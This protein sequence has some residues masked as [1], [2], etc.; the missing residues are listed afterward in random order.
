MGN[1]T[2]IRSARTPYNWR[3]LAILVGATLVSV[4]LLTPYSS[5]LQGQSLKMSPALLIGWVVMTA[6]VAIMAA[7]GLA[8]AGRIGLGLPF[9]ESWL[10]GRPDWVG[11]RKYV[12]PAI[13]TGVLVGIVIKG[14]DAVVFLPRLPEVVQLGLKEPPVW[15]GFLASFFGGI[16]EEIQLRLFMLTLFAWIGRFVNRTPEGRPGMGALWAANVLAAVLFGLGHLQG[17]AAAGVPLNALVITRAL[18]GNGLVGLV[19]GWLYWTFGLEAAMVSH[20]SFDIVFH[21]ISPLLAGQ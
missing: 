4:M 18:V 14:L 15:A 8:V 10:A 3:L 20:F 7:I 11:L 19:C 17:T 6:Q 2:S 13:L 12:W 9:L 5:A 16:T 21:V 1:E